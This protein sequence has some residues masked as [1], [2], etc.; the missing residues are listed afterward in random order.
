MHTE[1]AVGCRIPGAVVDIDE[2]VL[3]SDRYGERFWIILGSQIA[4]PK[5]E[6]ALHLLPPYAGNA[7]RLRPRLRVRSSIM[8]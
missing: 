2:I 8:D 1:R 7:V 5:P 4:A 6:P 3:G